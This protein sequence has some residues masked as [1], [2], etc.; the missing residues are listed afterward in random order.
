MFTTYNQNSFHLQWKKNLVKHQK[1]SQYYDQDC[2]CCN[3]QWFTSRWVIFQNEGRWKGRG[4]NKKS[5]IRSPFPLYCIG[6]ICWFFMCDVLKSFY[7]NA[8]CN[9]KS[10]KPELIAISSTFSSLVE[11][12]RF[13][14]TMVWKGIDKDCMLSGEKKVV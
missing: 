1:V 13:L 11:Y 8:A 12:V 7:Q 14:K 5:R 9:L 4:S 2:T 6:H 10:Y 3:L